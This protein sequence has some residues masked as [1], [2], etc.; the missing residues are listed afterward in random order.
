MLTVLRRIPSADRALVGPLILR[1]AIGAVFVGSGLQKLLGIWGGT[2]ISGTTAL[3]RA[4][5]I[6][7]AYPLALFVTWLELVGGS[8]LILGAFT[9]WVATPLAV[10][11]VVAIWKVHFAHG[12]FLNWTLRPGVGHGYEFNLV[13][14]AGLVCLIFAGPGALS[15]E[16][17]RARLHST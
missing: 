14:I 9:V 5:H 1:L 3:F 11:M 8:L 13:L 12:F 16:D 17:W 10:E 6:V 15:V 7:P 2:G 4:V